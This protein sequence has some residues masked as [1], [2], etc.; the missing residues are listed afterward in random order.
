MSA[1]VPRLVAALALGSNLGDRAAHLA[2]ARALLAAL[3]ATRLLAAS[4]EEETAPLGGLD[5]PPYLNQVLLVE[6][7]LAPPA[8]LEACQAVEALRGRRREA[9]WASRTLDVDIIEVDG[10]TSDA[11]ALV[12]PHPGLAERDFWRRQLAEARARLAASSGGDGEAGLP[13]WAVV[14]PKREAHIRRV[15]ALVEEW[16][17]RMAPPPEAARRWRRAAWLHDALRD[18]PVTELARLAPECRGPAELLH[19]PACANLLAAQGEADAELLDAVRHHSLGWP[20]WGMAGRVLYC[21]DF[22]EPGRRFDREARAA[23]AARFAA[24]PDAVLLEVVRRRLAHALAEGWIVPTQSSEFWNSLATGG[25]RDTG[26][27]PVPVVAPEAAG[28]GPAA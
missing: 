3:P 6:T 17:A 12:L 2:A 18:L 1:A 11:P 24:E 25:P 5:Q 16:I 28:D 26:E 23:L 19:G 7:A 13:A 22:L 27:R 20:A 14:S 10:V 8:L 4:A 15:V 9:R 21:A